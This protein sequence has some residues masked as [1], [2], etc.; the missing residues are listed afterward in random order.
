MHGQLPN[1]P[2]YEILGLI[3]SGDFA[4]VYRA[5]D[6]ELGREVA[7]KQIHA[8]YLSDPRRLE[9]FWREA[10]LLASLEHPHIMTIY[11]IVRPHG[12]LVLELMQGTVL[13][14]TRGQPID[15]GLLRTTMIST[16]Q[17]LALLHSRGTL[18][19][20]IKP[21]NLMVDRLGRIKV[22]DFG[23][24]R[25][26]ASDQGSYLKGATRYMA[27]E[28]VAPQFG[29][30]GPASDL[31]SLGFT[32]YELLCGAQQ[33]EMLFPGLDAFGRDK[34][35]AWM[36]WHAAADRKLPP[37]ASVLGGVPEDLAR[38]IERLTNKDQNRRHR[39][40]EQVLA[41]LRPAT[42]TAA[43]IDNSAEEEA[44]AKKR[45]TFHRRAAAA[46]ALLA[47]VLVS[48]LVLIYPSGSK[49]PPA[50]PPDEVVRGVVRNILPDLETLIIED[51]ATSGPREFRLESG[52][53]VLLNDQPGLL[54]DLRQLDQVS[55]R[56]A[57][58]AQGGQTL[59]VR[60]SRPQGDEG[61]VAGLTPDEGTLTIAR[62]G[63]QEL[64]VQVGPQCPITLN[65]VTKQDVRPLALTDLL[66]GDRVVVQHF[67]GEQGE[68][69]LAIAALRVV[70][71]QG[72]LRSVDSKL[73]KL[74]I[75][76][77]GASAVIL[78]AAERCEVT[79]NGRRVIDDR[80]LTLADLQ[81]GDAV[82][83]QRDVQLVS[84]A[85][86]REFQAGGTISAI[87]Y[88]V[89]S[90]VA[91]D[92]GSERTYLVDPACRI[93]LGGVEAA[94]TDLRR[95]DK[96]QATFDSPDAQSPQVTSLA[97]ERRADSGKWAILVVSATFDD[98]TLAP[99]PAAA[100][101]TSRLRAALTS[102]Y[103][104]SPDQIIVLEDSSRVR[105]EQAFPEAVAKAA[106]ADQ[107]LVVF[108]GR[109]AVDKSGAP[110]VAPKDFAAA[111][112]DDT[113]VALAP[114]LSAV[115]ASPVR[116][117]IVLLDLQAAAPAGGAASTAADMFRT[118]Q[119][120][121]SKPL[122]KTTNVFATTYAASADAALVAATTTAVAGEGDPNRDNLCELTELH[123]YFRAAAGGA[124]L[125]ELFL[126]NTN[127]PRIT[128]DAKEALRRLA[129]LM[130]QPKI[131]PGEVRILSLA[132][133]KLAP[134]EPEPK[135]LAALV[136]LDAKQH[137]EAIAG[138]RELLIERPA[139][140]LAWEASAWAKFEKR[141]YAE[142]LA[143]LTQLLRHL[144]ADAP[145]E[146]MLRV[147][148]WIGRLRE[149]SAVA[150]PADRKPPVAAIAALDSAVAA[151]GAKASE[152]F[153]QGRGAAREVLADFDR[154]I[155]AASE[156]SEIPRL[157]LERWQLRHHASFSC[158]A[159]AQEVLAHL[160]D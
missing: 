157:K 144:P 126:P 104:V 116:E 84:I 160:D 2:R 5:R 137:A 30:V 127:P 112:P 66:P 150:L 9:R 153:E 106:S 53:S 31:Y 147:L 119:G 34:Q 79:L 80:L 62:P 55:V 54:R 18:H 61:T 102:R 70:P 156:A 136:Q 12:W 114:L 141:S 120:T 64:V 4:A 149:L 69:A 25:R 11:D 63:G 92:R 87:N 76:A 20:D 145:E 38:V 140:P 134:K 99:F 52:D 124:S 95:G 94:W 24:A 27:P 118:I 8:Q 29:P 50:P 41:E 98:A 110:L 142:G 44:A 91:T 128:D 42:E 159:A 73:N 22:G 152:L 10:Q 58:D 111:R 26:V 37:V 88:D 36:M 90:F 51:S 146:T 33:F 133:S 131:D 57:H 117:K 15:L 143:D 82:T 59:E 125:I 72:V 121:R 43:E 60:V 129:A 67:A 101:Q 71:G 105:L 48:V 7:V 83:Y 100:E 85:A 81:P 35:V 97:A 78:P 74:T 65:G 158:Q 19:G 23:L 130:G 17:A 46:M 108:A 113:G 89:R 139:T 14:V 75:D 68:Q 93:T 32:A 122:L 40:A 45:A 6:R 3:G 47:S 154:R 138:L 103:A 96:V 155:A 132:A 28:T 107:L 109:A 1:H 39:S 115:E 86:Q 135:L 13:D 123:E 148:P 21:S 56:I 49:P 16:L 77:G 151:R